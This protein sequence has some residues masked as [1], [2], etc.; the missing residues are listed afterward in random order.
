MTTNHK[1]D[2]EKLVITLGS[3]LCMINLVKKNHMVD[4]YNTSPHSLINS[5][6]VQTVFIVTSEV[7]SCD[8]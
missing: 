3:S 8:A 4:K 2:T 7:L 6:T 5:L 1:Q